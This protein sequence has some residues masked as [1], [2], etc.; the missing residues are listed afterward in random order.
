MQ[1][2]KTKVTKHSLNA[3]RCFGVVAGNHCI[4][5]GYFEGMPHLVFFLDKLPVY[6][7]G[8]KECTPF[9]IFTFYPYFAIHHLRNPLTDGKSQPGTAVFSCGRNI[10]LGKGFEQVMEEVAYTWFNRFTALRFMDVSDLNPVR[11]IS[12]LSGQF[13][14]E[15]LAEAK[16]GNIDEDRVPEKV[17]AQARALLDGRAPSP[18]AQAE[19]YRLLLVA[20]CND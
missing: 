2:F 7:G 3:R 6:G 1:H 12:P 18:D 19:A 14:P 20:I 17:H 5:S 11:V 15:I 4:I 16:A 8:E 10:C 13:Q 9:T